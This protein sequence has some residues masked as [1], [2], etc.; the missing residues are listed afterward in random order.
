MAHE[1]DKV[2]STQGG[3]WHGLGIRIAAGLSAV[4]AM[5]AHKLCFP[6]VRRPV[7]WQD[8]TGAYHEVESHAAN[9][10]TLDADGNQCKQLLGVVGSEY[11]ICQNQ[12][13]AEFADACS[14]TGKVQVETIGS[15]QGGKKVWILA[16][17]EDFNVNGN[18]K[19]TPYIA[20]SNSHDGTN[21]IR[22]TPTTVRFVCSNTF[23]MVIPH[24]DD[25]MQRPET[26]AFVIRHTGNISDKLEQAKRAIRY[27]SETLKRNQELFEALQAKRMD[28]DQRMKLF[29]DIYAANWEVAT[30]EELGSK[31]EKVRRTAE[32]RLRRMQEASD[33]FI[34]RYADEQSKLGLGDSAWAAVNAMTGFI[35]HDKRARGENDQNRVEKRIESNLFGINATRTL[36][37]FA[38]AMSM[39]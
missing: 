26:A 33:L 3:E 39:V 18:D 20:F 34:Q 6:V 8:E 13:L 14:Q 10:R 12:E 32:N 27:Y 37:T 7:F 21:A 2:I 36:D 38:H 15:I 25:L 17:G 31:D 19:I 29:A 1:I 35:Q 22:V 30:P 28:A 4:A 16:K 5:I 11:Q 23:H 9:V 24:R